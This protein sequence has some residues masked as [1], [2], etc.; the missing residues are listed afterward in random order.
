MQ[1]HAS[2]ITADGAYHCPVSSIMPFFAINFFHK[3]VHI[4]HSSTIIICPM[5]V[6]VKKWHFDLKLLLTCENRIIGSVSVSSKTMTWVF[7]NDNSIPPKLC[8]KI[9]IWE[10]PSN[11]IERIECF[12]FRY[13][14][15]MCNAIWVNC[16]CWGNWSMVEGRFSKWF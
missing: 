9:K 12:S 1:Y 10:H 4:E 13:P 11:K 8:P 16:Y 14:V 6:Y 2:L 3:A 7:K 15:L 5:C